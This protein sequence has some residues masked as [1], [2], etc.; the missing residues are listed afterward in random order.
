M[1]KA[2]KFSPRSCSPEPRCQNWKKEEQK[3]SS[4]MRKSLAPNFETPS[5]KTVRRLRHRRKI[6]RTYVRSK[7]VK[8]YSDMC[9][10]YSANNYYFLRNIARKNSKFYA[11]KFHD[12]ANEIT[13]YCSKQN[14]SY[15]IAIITGT[16]HIVENK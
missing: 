14:Y 11:L 7:K 13:N 8:N 12:C 3:N 5:K 6:T 2:L 15:N 10:R 9:T 1:R 4:F 16:R